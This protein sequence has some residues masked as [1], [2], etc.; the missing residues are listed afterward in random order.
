MD[1]PKLKGNN[2][3]QIVTASE[4]TLLQL[5]ISQ[6]TCPKNVLEFNIG[7]KKLQVAF[8]LKSLMQPAVSEVKMEPGTLLWGAKVTLMGTDCGEI[9]NTGS[10]S[11]G[12]IKGN[13]H[14]YRCLTEPLIAMMSL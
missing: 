11:T 12:K 4:M 9:C 7:G 8:F 3:S 14:P 13:F 2:L 5:H 1:L 10:K 6:G